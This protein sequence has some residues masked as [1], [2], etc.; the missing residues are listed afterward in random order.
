MSFEDK[1]RLQLR[2]ALGEGPSLELPRWENVQASEPPRRRPCLI[3]GVLRRG[4]VGLFSGR[5][6]VGK[7]WLGMQLCV[8]VACAVPW[9]GF[10]VERGNALMLDPELDTRSLDG[11]FAKVCAAM[12]VNSSEADKHIWRWSLRGVRKADG[13][14]P[15]LDDVAHDM[16]ELKAFDMLPR[17]D[18]IFVDSM[19]ALMR[20]DENSSRDVRKNF[21]TLLEIA[22]TTGASVLCAHHQG[23]GQS[24]DRNAQD[25]ARGSSAFTDCPDLILSL[26]EIEPPNGDASDYI[27]E[28]RRALCLTCAGIR[29]FA[30]F[31]DVH[32]IWDYPTHKLDIEN[33]TQGWKPRSSQG[34]AGKASGQS[35]QDAATLKRLACESALLA[36]FHTHGIGA[37]GITAKDAADV[38]SK[39]LGKSINS[40]TLKN[41][42]KDEPNSNVTV[43]QKS[44]R[45]CMF[46]PTHLPHTEHG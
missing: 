26:D 4:H 13:N 5:A 16:R 20:G 40:T 43:W 3:D 14:A 1:E 30:T 8:A 10:N 22:E 33:L 28:G 31:P 17:F 18:L 42:F 11:R 34:K 9:L 36:H 38:C 25:R 32:L 46:V 41:L 24:G 44:A 21:N 29:E 15:T 37:E 45:R 6:K 23:K 7:S 39:A 35:R 19:A 27:G 2:V 12:G